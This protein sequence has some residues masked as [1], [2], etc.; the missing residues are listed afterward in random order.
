MRRPL[1]VAAFLLV[2]F[3]ASVV[4]ASAGDGDRAVALAAAVRTK[5]L[6]NVKF[7]GT[8][9]DDVLK[10]LKVATG[11]NFVVKRDVLAKA[12]IDPEQVTAKVELT[13]VTVGTFL[14]ILLEPHGLVTKI[15]GNVIF[16][17]TKA[18]ALGKPIVVLHPI[19]HITWQKTDFHGRKMDLHPSGYTPE[20]EPEETLVEDDPLTDPQHIVDLVKQIVDAPWDTE[21]WAISANKT[22]L[23]C[24]APRVIQL[25]VAR[26]LA[27]IASFK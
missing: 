5:R 8:K 15:E 1:L 25:Q 12:N 2:P 18:D 16:V 10:W 26:A 9:L 27:V 23:T 20:E 6:K 3:V 17:T 14:E 21:G 22:F 11:W 4:P 13:D 7:D 24:R 19:S